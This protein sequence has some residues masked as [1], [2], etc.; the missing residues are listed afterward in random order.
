MTQSQTHDGDRRLARLLER[1]TRLAEASLIINEGLEMEVLLQRVLDSA[2]SLTGALYGVLT[3][4]DQSG[5]LDEFFASGLSSEE[6]RQLWRMP[7]GEELLEH[8]NAMREPWRV[9]DFAG[10]I[11]AMGLPEFRPPV[12]TSAFLTVPILHRGDRVGNI[13]MSKRDPGQEFSRED[14]EISVMFAAQAAMVI[15]NARRYRDERRARTALETLVETSPV[16]VA[17]FDATTGALVSINREMTRIADGLKDE[18]Q[19]LEQF[20]ET[21]SCRRVDGQEFSLRE[22]PLAGMLVAGETVRAE[23]ITLSVPDGRS[24]NAL[25]NATPVRSEGGEVEVCVVTLQ[26]M[27]PLE[28][29]ERLRAEFLGM[30]SHELRAP[31]ASIRGSATTVLDA[32]A[33]LEPAEL[34]QFLRIIVDQADTIREL[35]GDLLDVARIETGALSVNPEPSNVA[36][37]VDRARTTFLSGGGRHNLDIDLAPDLPL[38]SADRRRIVQVIGNLLSNAARHSSQAST[39][40]VTTAWTG[41]QVAVSVADTGLGIPSEQLPRLFRRFSR[42]DGDDPGLG[43]AICRGIVE[44]HGGRIRAES[45]G[46]GMGATFTFTLPAVEDTT[47]ERRSLSASERRKAGGS[48]VDVL[49]V[50]D[51]PQTLMQARKALS[52]AGYHPIVTSNPQEALRLMAENRPR[53]VLLDMVLPGVE[54]IDLMDELIA[55][56]DVPV[57]FLSAYGGDHVIARAF[58]MGAADY[59][60]KPFSST[61]LVVRVGAVLRR[62]ASPYRSDPAEPYVRDGLTIDY[63]RRHVTVSG[64]T[65]QLTP[66][67]YGLLRALAVNAGRT[68][69][70]EQV[71]LQVWGYGAGDLPSLRSLLLRLRRKLGEDGGDP[72][73]I[74]TVPHVGYRMEAPETTQQRQP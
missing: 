35:I 13:H 21:L 9:A 16:G 52:E 49:V 58:E 5:R 50:D 28:E 11:S 15:A 67:E 3:T 4:L 31:L 56:A 37:L 60:V 69:T 20:L 44:A 73:W 62:Q 29:Q 57:V 51:E 34:R 12:P 66:K 39:I 18:E 65:V 25:L 22:W 41:S 14:E 59:L 71:L 64:R 6:A 2:R 19:S 55:V 68:L 24:V 17:V 32:P 47:I 46:R 63:N 30:V 45:G 1:Q 74:F 70:H 27:E 36:E 7:G 33:E 48:G 23:E 54:G 26:D 10:Y 38:V 72:I 40:R 42:V 53:L 43:L 61:E 8:L